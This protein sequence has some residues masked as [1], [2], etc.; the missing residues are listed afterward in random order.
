MDQKL[1]KG[2]AVVRGEKL[3]TEIEKAHKNSDGKKKENG[4]ITN[5]ENSE[6]ESDLLQG[7]K[8]NGIA[9]DR[10]HFQHLSHHKRK[11]TGNRRGREREREIDRDRE[12]EGRAQRRKF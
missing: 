4:V 12:E 6:S 11:T 10:L 5:N 1:G 8:Q 3:S 2:G 7:I 9:L